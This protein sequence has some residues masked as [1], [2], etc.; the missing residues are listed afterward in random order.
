MNAMTEAQAFPE[1][2][3]NLIPGPQGHMGE[4]FGALALAQG[5][6]EP[7]EKNKEVTIR[8]REKPSYT[9]S[10]ADLAEIRAKTT[11]ALSKNGLALA[12]I[13]TNKP[14]HVGGV[15]MRTILGHA[16]GARME[17][18]LDIAKGRDNEVK[19]FGAF[20][21]Y[22]RRYAVSALLGIAADSDL[23]DDEEPRFDEPVMGNS[24]DTSS[25]RNPAALNRAE[26]PQ[27]RAAKSV[28]ELAAIFNKFSQENKDRFRPQYERLLEE[29]DT[30]AAAS[31]TDKPAAQQSAPKD[32]L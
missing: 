18:V 6:F 3:L 17:S 10:Y 21:T 12:Q 22:M 13:V 23:D 5:A 11:P 29:L 31:S 28:K 1:I 9:F 16:S 27:L 20:V 30:P 4:F 25:P 2:D 14:Q 15:Q 24:A 26:S 19:D 8:P 7:I 32:D